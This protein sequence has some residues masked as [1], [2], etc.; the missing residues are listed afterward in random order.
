MISEWCKQG[1]CSRGDVERTSVHGKWQ[2]D[3]QKYD[4]QHFDP[5][6]ENGK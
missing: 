6:C 2:E 3:G 4:R 5:V 1:D